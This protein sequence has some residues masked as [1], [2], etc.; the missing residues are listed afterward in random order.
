VN[1]KDY[2][3]SGIIESYVMGL[4]SESERTEFEQYC[5]QYPELVAERRKFEEDLEQFA[6]KNA[7]PAPQKAFAAVKVKISEGNGT[8]RITTSSNPPKIITMEKEKSPVRNSGILRFVAA[9]SV[10][11]LAGMAWMYIQSSQQNKDLTSTN[12]RLKEK[13]NSTDSILNQIVR[14]QSEQKQVVGDPNATV[15][16]MVGTKVAP[17]SSA[18]IYWDSTSSSVYLV[19][20]NM[21]K[22]PNDQQ[23]QLWALIDGK[24]NDLGVFDATDHK[25]ILKMKNTKKAQAFAI[26][27]EKQGGAPSPTLEKMQSLGKTL[28]T[29]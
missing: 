29:Q 15:V 13:L 5:S 14:E 7:E 1:L 9:A 8:S 27:I 6:L 24:P 4:A 26:T 10:V 20:K 3:E 21:P 18:N 22:L 17:K 11:L 2:I 25:V 16:N 23:Y 28:Q 19:V 12:D